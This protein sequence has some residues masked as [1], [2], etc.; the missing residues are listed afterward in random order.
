ML[1]RLIDISLI[2]GIS[3]MCFY[4]GAQGTRSQFQGN[5]VSNQ[6][7]ILFYNKSKTDRS[8]I[9]AIVGNRILVGWEP[10][11]ADFETQPANTPKI[12]SERHSEDIWAFYYIGNMVAS[13]TRMPTPEE[14]ESAYQSIGIPN[15]VQSLKRLLR[16]NPSNLDIC[17]ALMKELERYAIRKTRQALNLTANNNRLDSMGSTIAPQI[18]EMLDDQSD[19]N[20]WG[21]LADM[22]SA[23]FNSGD[24]VSMLPGFFARGQLE[25]MALYSPKMKALYKK[26]LG[27]V[28]RELE[29]RQNDINLW[30]MWQEM[31]QA[32]NRK[33]LDYF[34][35]LPTLPEESGTVWPPVNVKEWMKQEARQNNLWQKLVEMSWPEWPMIQSSLDRWAPV[36]IIPAD[37]D[38]ADPLNRNRYAN[39]YTLPLLEACLN[40]KEFVKANEIY[41]DISSRPS[42]EKE[43]RQAVEMAKA[44]NHTFPQAVPPQKSRT[45]DEQESFLGDP[46][47]GNVIRQKSREDALEN[48]STR[49]GLLYLIIIEPPKPSKV[50][51][52]NAFIDPQTG[53]A[54]TNTPAGAEEEDLFKKNLLFLLNQAGLEE[55]TVR[56]YTWKHDQPIA[57]ELI[58]RERLPKNT[59]T[60]GILD[61]NKKYYHGGHSEPSSEAIFEVVKSTGIKSHTSIYKEFADKH[62]D[63]VTA[64]GL[65]LISYWGTAHYRTLSAE[66]DESGYI[67]DSSDWEIWTDYIRLATVL[68]PSILARPDFIL[69]PQNPLN[70][71]TI[72]NSKLLQQFARRYIES[73]E[74]AL[75]NRPHTKELWEIWVA[76]APF[77]NRS[78]PSFMETLTPVPDQSGFPPT[79][80]YPALIK[81]YKSLDAWT[82][83]INLVEPIWETY[84][85]RVDAEESISHRLTRNLLVEYVNPLCEAYEK[86]G[87]WTKAEKIRDT[88]TKADGW[89]EPR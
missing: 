70:A 89:S 32:S 87:Q 3:G 50:E 33:I 83:I 7:G 9:N 48:L 74:V 21:E 10:L 60:W 2:L 66:K 20:I 26:N 17:L 86:L 14:L 62:P 64:K 36:G 58:E 13:G 6:Q 76:F 30:K 56:P 77:T 71:P 54:M 45:A 49:K 79:F 40:S 31:A 39:G 55:Y 11:V 72:K 25:N 22:F 85:N 69:W 8:A 37:R 28:E 63:S 67:S 16:R 41:F 84:Q 27:T 59:Y 29:A 15:K 1:R 38:P 80:V 46:I 53:N 24:W 75:Q 61:N 57:E 4:L 88:W 19:A 52:L 68:L 73:V 43:T 82:Q 81:E 44:V 65:L 78:L 34:P 23:S 12:D 5:A 47:V 18:T 51:Q 35:E 42:L